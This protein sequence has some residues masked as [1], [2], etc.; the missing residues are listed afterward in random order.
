MPHP[1]TLALCGAVSALAAYLLW[2]THEIVIAPSWRLLLLSS[3][4]YAAIGAVAG[5][6]GVRRVMAP[7]RGRRRGL[8][9]R[10]RMDP[11]LIGAA[12][13]IPMPFV[14]AWYGLLL[15]FL[16]GA[17]FVPLLWLPA[18]AG[19][20]VGGKIRIATWDTMAGG[21]GEPGPRG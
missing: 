13:V 12:I 6:I 10:Y 15:G 2:P 5:S 17:I 14:M 16:A 9:P 21:D 19:A 3:A 20:W 4:A 7:R 18:A 1:A 11:G 8:A